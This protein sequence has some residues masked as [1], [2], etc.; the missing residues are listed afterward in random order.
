MKN[1]FILI[2]VGFFTPALFAQSS[3][4]KLPFYPPLETEL[5]HEKV[6][7]DI[8]PD[9]EYRPNVEVYINGE[10][11]FLFG[12]DWGANAF[13][14][15]DEL[16]RK[17]SLKKV[18]SYEVMPGRTEDYV[19]VS[20]L[21]IGG[22][23][24]IGS[25]AF[26]KEMLDKRIQGVLGFNVF[27]HVLMTFDFPNKELIL[28]KGELP[29]P[30]NENIYSLATPEEGERPDIDVSI[31]DLKFKATLD[32]R[33]FGWLI[34]NE[35]YMDDLTTFGPK[36]EFMG[37]GP[38][39]GTMNITA[40]RVKESLMVGSMEV[41]NPIVKFR[42][43]PGAIIGMDFMKNFA[44]TLDKQNHTVKFETAESLPLTPEEEF[45]EKDS[46]D[47]SSEM[48]PDKPNSY[49]GRY[50]IRTIY[51]ENG[52]LYIQRDAPGATTTDQNGQRVK[53]V[54]PKLQLA[55]EGKNEFT[56]PRIPGAKVKFVEN[57]MGEITELHVLNRGGEWEK[58]K[59][60]EE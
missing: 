42:N 21:Q 24:F 31:G 35:E 16:S 59:R 51:Y 22:A 17:L 29:E 23:H 18:G 19:E 36:D 28:K 50:G 49:A 54:T 38:Q 58:A 2:L 37:Q 41:E 40:T 46:S 20:E 45:W 7:V 44:I 26:A 11:P 12:I 10:G 14:I 52:Q 4:L 6:M 30:D 34:I 25:T 3:D 13:V 60:D 33:A 56:I 57:S 9:D 43:R 53:M 1:N 47:L 48:M 15:S 27:E 8:L 32:T 39:M 5:S 55:Y